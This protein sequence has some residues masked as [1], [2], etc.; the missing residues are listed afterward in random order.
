MSAIFG[1]KEKAK[2]EVS[3]SKKEPIV[4]APKSSEKRPEGKS[5]R[6]THGVLL[7]PYLTE[8]SSTLAEG[9]TYTFLVARGTE[10]IQIA[11]AIHERY[12]VAP[13]H[14]RIVNLPGK[15]VRFGKTS[16]WRAGRRKALIRL[17]A[18]D[19]IPFGVRTS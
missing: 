12:G 5:L 7:E 10:K 18:G 8:K 9:G 14:V 6:T 17:K 4:V 13:A 15:H 16:G 3:A 2:D 11:R 19:A 1:K